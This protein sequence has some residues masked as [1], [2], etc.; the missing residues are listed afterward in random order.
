MMNPRYLPDRSVDF[1]QGDQECN[2]YVFMIAEVFQLVDKSNGNYQLLRC[3]LLYRVNAGATA[4]WGI[5]SL[6]QES[7]C[8]FEKYPLFG[9]G[10]IFTQWPGTSM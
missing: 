5:R 4:T 10:G 7:P 3:G 8:D 2:V 1:G 9:L 6:V